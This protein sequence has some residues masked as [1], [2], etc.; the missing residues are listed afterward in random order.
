M[1]RALS[2]ADA[3]RSGAEEVAILLQTHGTGGLT[4]QQVIMLLP[5]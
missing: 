5:G 4:D 2:S 3:A 1:L